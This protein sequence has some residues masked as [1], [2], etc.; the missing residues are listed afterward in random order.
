MINK[1]D[2]LTQ[3]IH[4]LL[5]KSDHKYAG[6]GHE[7]SLEGVLERS[8]SHDDCEIVRFIIDNVSYSKERDG[9][10][11]RGNMTP[12]LRFMRDVVSDA[13]KVEA[14]GVEGLQ[15]CFTYSVHIHPD[16]STSELWS[17]VSEHLDEKLL[18]LLDNYIR[19]VGGREM[20]REGHDF[21][22]KWKEERS[23]YDKKM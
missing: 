12:Q 3:Y 11:D 14:L 4:I 2:K 1:N 8:F 6:E 5:N 16:Y 17:R 18:G 10:V 21:L 15:R 9:K 7:K 23:N 19:T 22:V 13:D 20:A